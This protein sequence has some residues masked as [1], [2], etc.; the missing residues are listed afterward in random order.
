MCLLNMNPI[1]QIEPSLLDGT[2]SLRKDA[3]IIFVCGK[4]ITADD[5]KRKIFMEYADRHLKGFHFL[6]AEKYFSAMED[7]THNLLTIENRLADYS[8]GIII[9]LESESTFAELGA[10]AISDKLCKKILPVNDNR[11]IKSE[12]FI[13]LGPLRKIDTSLNNLGPTIPANMRSITHCF[14]SI[15]DRLNK[16]KRKN[17]KRL[18]LT[19]INKFNSNHKERL[20]LIYEI[21]NLF[22][23]ITSKEIYQYFS[24]IYNKARL[25][26]IRFDLVLLLALGLANKNE[27][28]YIS[29][30]PGISF[31]D[32]KSTRN[33]TI[34]SK[35]ILYYKRH[36]PN[37]LSYLPC[38]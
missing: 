4:S 20:L 33:F 23:P 14:S 22:G 12:S 9:I 17:A 6:L 1:S 28:F 16:I 15:N 37:R 24:D 32:F 13:N 34:R 3:L 5:S 21:I 10:F 19:D 35:T 38:K 30:K 11:F 26:I 25:D 31:I 2:P 8:D 18:N 36:H 27:N 29:A 7:K